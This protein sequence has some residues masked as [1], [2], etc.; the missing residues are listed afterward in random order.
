MFLEFSMSI[1]HFSIA[2]A[3][4]IRHKIS[5]RIYFLISSVYIV[6]RNKS[7]ICTLSF[8]LFFFT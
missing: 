4:E 3:K 1:L 5:L 2:I 6:F 7:S 8:L